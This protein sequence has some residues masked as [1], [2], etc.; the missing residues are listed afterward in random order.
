MK[1][2]ALLISLALSVPAMADSVPTLA[3]VPLTLA[4]SQTQPLGDTIDF[5]VTV[6]KA[7]ELAGH[8]AAYR[9]IAVS[10]LASDKLAISWQ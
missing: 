9:G 3:A 8:L 7:D 4:A 1:R 10:R 5:E 6:T 2:L